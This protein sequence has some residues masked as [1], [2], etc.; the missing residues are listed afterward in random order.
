MTIKELR[1]SIKYWNETGC[2]LQ[3]IMIIFDKDSFGYPINY[4]RININSIILGYNPY[5]DNE[6]TVTLMHILDSTDYCTQ[7][8]IEV[9]FET[10]ET[11]YPIEQVNKDYDIYIKEA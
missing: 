5:N 3:E 10:N 9:H 11:L 1:T 2:D 7:E 8:D 4:M 6:K